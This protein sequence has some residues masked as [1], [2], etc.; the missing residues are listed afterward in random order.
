MQRSALPV[1][2]T[3]DI[4]PLFF[5]EVKRDRLIPLRCH[6]KHIDTEIVLN[7][8]VASILKHYLN[9]GEVPSE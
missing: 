3:F 1:V 9:Q 6:M 7:M 8:H 2:S 4:K 5:E